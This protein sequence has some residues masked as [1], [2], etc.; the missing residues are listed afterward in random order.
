MS[1][2]ETRSGGAKLVIDT[3]AMSNAIAQVGTGPVNNLAASGAAI[4]EGQV[5]PS[6][7]RFIG[8]KPAK[9]FQLRQDNQ[10]RSSLSK[11]LRI[12]VALIFN[13]S[14]FATYQ[15]VGSTNTR[16]RRPLGTAFDK[17]RSKPG[18]R[19]VRRGENK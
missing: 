7:A 16:P 12:P 9:M 3:E 4:A 1:K 18:V 8:W 13:N 15:E 19:G 14:L 10:I 5:K 2:W 17:L 11:K 6:V